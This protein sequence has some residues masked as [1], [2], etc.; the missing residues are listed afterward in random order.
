M[1]RDAGGTYTAPS[2]SFNPAVEGTAIDEGDWNTTLDDVEAAFTESVFT[3]GM[4]ATDNRLVRTDGTSTKKVQG[5]GI[6]VSDADAV[7]GVTAL[8]TSGT[9][10]SLT[11]VNTTDNASVEIATF[12]GDRAT[13]ANNDLAYISLKLSDSAGNQDAFARIKWLATDVT[14]T[15]ED[16]KL[17]F[18]V[19]TGGTLADEVELTGT[20]FSPAASDGN[21]LGTT[22]LMWSDLFLASGGVINANNGNATIT[23]SAGLWTFNVPI[24]HAVYTVATLPGTA[25]AG[26]TAYAS[27]GRKNGEGA[28]LGTGV[29]VFGDG[30]A[31]RA[32]DTGATVAA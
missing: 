22:A 4:G 29:V 11:A 14:S 6:T 30:T 26:A 25:T 3:A 17:F 15:S 2:N 13:M 9:A 19:A 28:G 20:S 23:H 27:D 21:A 16:G 8:T 5:T 18:G 24:V 7:T 12:E 32:V 31:W 10:A 1:A